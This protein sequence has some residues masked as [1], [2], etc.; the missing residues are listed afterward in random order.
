MTK[1]NCALGLEEIDV[2]S[3]KPITMR[4]TA[5]R[6][7]LGEVLGAAVPTRAVAEESNSSATL[8]IGVRGAELTGANINHFLMLMHEVP[9]IQSFDDSFVVKL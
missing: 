3:S 5:S 7:S 8:Q 4:A 6:N 9:S 2:Q 1:D